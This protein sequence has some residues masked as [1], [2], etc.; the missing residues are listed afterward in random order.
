[1]VRAGRL[2]VGVAEVQADEVPE[3]GDH[4]LLSEVTFGDA[5]TVTWYRIHWMKVHRTVGTVLCVTCGW[6]M[7]AGEVSVDVL[8]SH[9]MKTR[10]LIVVVHAN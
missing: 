10:E 7:Q 3:L 5:S 2:V 1:V 9:V 4:R 8:A 6:W